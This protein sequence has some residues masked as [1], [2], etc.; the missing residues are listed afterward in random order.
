MLTDTQIH[1]TRP[2]NRQARRIIR[3][4]MPTVPPKHTTPGENEAASFIT[5]KEQYPFRLKIM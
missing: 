5:M 3:V 2:A 4:C 1:G